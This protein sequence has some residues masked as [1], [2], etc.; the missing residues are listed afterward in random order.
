MVGE[1]Q[2]RFFVQ[3]YNLQHG[4]T[5]GAVRGLYTPFPACFVS[6][7]FAWSR[8]LAVRTRCHSSSCSSSIIEL[9]MRVVIRSKICSIYSAGVR[10]QSPSPAPSRLMTLSD[11]RRSQH[12]RNDEKNI[13]EREYFNGK[14]LERNP[15]FSS[16]TSRIKGFSASA[17][18]PLLGPPF[19]FTFLLPL[20]PSH[21][22]NQ[23]Q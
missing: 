23:S 12:E 14:T 15:Y 19:L 4:A 2:S 22:L 21:L 11:G 10:S 9:Y 3:E 7:V 20:P 5:G 6:V 1:F 8:D 17:F 13:T 18:R 16:Y